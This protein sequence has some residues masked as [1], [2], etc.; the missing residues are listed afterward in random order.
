MNTHLK[1]GTIPDP[2]YYPEAALKPNSDSTKEANKDVNSTWI[3]GRPKYNQ[4]ECIVSELTK[5]EKAVLGEH[6]KDKIDSRGDMIDL[7]A[8]FL[9]K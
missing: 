9:F 5:E 3:S 4:Y 7:E 6:E 2:H 1:A 8:G